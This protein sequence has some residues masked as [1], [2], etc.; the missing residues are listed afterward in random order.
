MIQEI[1]R[2]KLGRFIHGHKTNVGKVVSYET[3]KKISR[4]HIGKVV[5][6][7]TRE[8]QRISHLG[9]KMSES[10]KEKLRLINSGSNT[11]LWKGGISKPNCSDCDKIISWR[12]KKCKPCHGK[13]R[14]GK[15][16]H[17]WKGGIEN[18][19]WHNNKRRITKKGNGGSHSLDEWMMLKSKHDWKCVHCGVSEPTIK[20]TRD[21]I[22]PISKE[23]TD[24]IENIQPL[25]KSCN[26][27]K[28]D[29]V[30]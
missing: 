5:T 21:H 16:H 1:N 9:Y 12:A 23:G 18:K 29:H 20:L 30:L 14:T 26:S 19:L 15:N 7:E 6:D 13:D 17:R 3:R 28:H 22:I 4:G 11:H 25:C 8:K 27:K 24:D 2:N 10:A